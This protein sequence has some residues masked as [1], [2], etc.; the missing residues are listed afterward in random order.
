MEAWAIMRGLDFCV[1]EGLKNVLLRTDAK[2]VL[3][4]ILDEESFKKKRSNIVLDSETMDFVCISREILEGQR[5]DAEHICRQLNMSV[6]FIARQARMM[7]EK[8]MLDVNTH[9]LCMKD[10]IPL[11]LK[12]ILANDMGFPIS[13]QGG[14]MVITRH[15]RFKC[16]EFLNM[17]M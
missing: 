9:K 7:E 6:D 5:W 11:G 3:E 1:N 15:A 10:D 16:Q 13:L 12:N 4:L 8:S 2:Y 17:M 14:Y